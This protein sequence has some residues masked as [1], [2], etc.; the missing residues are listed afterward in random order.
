MKR[1]GGFVVLALCLVLAGWIATLRPE[2][3]EIDRPAGP[4]ADGIA[5]T[6]RL[7][8]RLLQVVAATEVGTPS[9]AT[10]QSW[11]PFLV[12][13]YWVQPHQRLL[14]GLPRI[15][16]AEGKRYDPVTRI[17]LP[18]GSVQVPV[19]QAAVAQAVFEVPAA[20]LRG[21][22]FSVRSNAAGGIVPVRDAPTF[23]LP[24][25]VPPA[26]GPVTIE[27]PTYEAGR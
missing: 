25:P 18:A 11:E 1:L 21:A 19:A 23:V 27:E 5:R 13:T 26:A 15:T 7:D 9:G 4:G 6:P 22:R 24:D 3:T 20:K 12:V 14:T 2:G 8:A 10:Q 17:G 16:T